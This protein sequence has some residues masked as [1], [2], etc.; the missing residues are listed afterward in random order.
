MHLDV[1]RKGFGFLLCASYRY[2]V[3]PTQGNHSIQKPKYNACQPETPCISNM[4][5]FSAAFHVCQVTLTIL[6]QILFLIHQP[7]VF[8]QHTPQPNPSILTS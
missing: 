1:S 2:A 5:L 8:Q 3:L 6:L 4:N 7:S